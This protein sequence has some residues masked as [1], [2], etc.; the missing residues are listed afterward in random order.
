MWGY[1]KWSNLKI[2]ESMN[3]CKGNLKDGIPIV[4]DD[5]ITGEK[6]NTDKWNWEGYDKDM[7][8]TKFE[9]EYIP[10]VKDKSGARVKLRKYQ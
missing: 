8:P 6:I 7:K 4:V 5:M 3:Y 10:G 2:V 9:C 1:G